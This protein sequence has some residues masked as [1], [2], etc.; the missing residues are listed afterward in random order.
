MATIV[1]TPAHEHVASDSGSNSAV[2][3][4]VG[5][6]VVLAVA[7]L[8]YYFALPMMRSANNAAAPQITAPQVKVPDKINVDVNQNP[9]QPAQ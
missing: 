9:A 3:L 8:L 7:F 2:N 5:V 1:N 4:L 6:L